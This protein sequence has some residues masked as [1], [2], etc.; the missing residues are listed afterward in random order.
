MFS[1]CMIAQ[2]PRKVMLLCYC[3][4]SFPL[5]RFWFS[6][7]DKPTRDCPCTATYVQTF[8][9]HQFCSKPLMWQAQELHVCPVKVLVCT[10]GWHA[11]FPNS[12]IIGIHVQTCWI[13]GGI[14]MAIS[15]EL[16][17]VLCLK[18]LELRKKLPK[19]IIAASEYLLQLERSA[20]MIR[21][22]NAVLI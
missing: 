20:R 9:L 6:I 10:S 4:K 21:S 16:N 18:L 11:L 3:I 8:Q 5:Q 22:P 1:I 2:V 12:S 17:S 15:S 7:A 14:N 13:P 19:A